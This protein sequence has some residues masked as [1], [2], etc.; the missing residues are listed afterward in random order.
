MDAFLRTFRMASARCLRRGGN[1]GSG[2]PGSAIHRGRMSV[3]SLR[4]RSAQAATRPIQKQESRVG[5]RK[6]E[7]AKASKWRT[8]A[9]RYDAG[10]LSG[11]AHLAHPI[12][13]WHYPVDRANEPPLLIPQN[14]LKRPQGAIVF[15]TRA[16]ISYNI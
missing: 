13:P 4:N 14:L 2:S 16:C 1:S 3:D 5:C 12:V 15:E 6:Q 10:P 11:V 8:S 7:T 9:C